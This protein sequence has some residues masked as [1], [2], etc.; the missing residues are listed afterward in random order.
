MGGCGGLTRQESMWWPKLGLGHPQWKRRDGVGVVAG[1][2]Y[3]V[4]EMM[5]NGGTKWDFKKNSLE[6]GLGK[7]HRYG[8]AG[9]NGTVVIWCGTSLSC[10]LV[11]TK[12]S[13]PSLAVCLALRDTKIYLS[14]IIFQSRIIGRSMISLFLRHGLCLWSGNVISSLWL[15]VISR[16]FPRDPH[17]QSSD[18]CPSLWVL[19]CLA[20]SLASDK[21]WL[22]CQLPNYRTV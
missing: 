5:W 17:H 2:A 12:I 13:D 16:G 6:A 19:L 20:A 4:W 14:H 21:Q 8:S 18:R 9:T 10:C 11:T 7:W 22:S 15:V 1:L 3:W